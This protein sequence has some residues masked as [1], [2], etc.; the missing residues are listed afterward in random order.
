MVDGP[1]TAILPI[2]A[3][4][5]AHAVRIASNLEL[6]MRIVSVDLACEQSDS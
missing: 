4:D 1:S 5:A 6:N 3:R 2:K